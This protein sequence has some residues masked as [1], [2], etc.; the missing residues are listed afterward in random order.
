MTDR[1]GSKVIESTPEGDVVTHLV[2]RKYAKAF[3][4][5]N[6]AAEA[7]KAAAP[8]QVQQQQQQQQQPQAQAPQSSAAPALAAAAAAAAALPAPIG[9]PEGVV[10]E[11]KGQVVE[12]RKGQAAEV[13]SSS[14]FRKWEPTPYWKMIGR[15]GPQ[16]WPNGSKV[17]EVEKHFLQ[18][19]SLSL[20]IYIYI[21]I[22]FTHMTCMYVC[23]YVYTC[24]C[25]SVY[26]WS[27]I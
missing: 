6:P 17:R 12:E 13:H 1:L 19:L 14:K 2:T 25:I 22:Y 3:P 18:V 26:I 20:S 27:S 9:R 4:D 10:E 16:S 7:V 5:N 11:R 23:I 21:Y 15:N 24:V 8:L